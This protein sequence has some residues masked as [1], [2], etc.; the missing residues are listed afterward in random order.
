VAQINQDRYEVLAAR[1]LGVKGA[2]I[3]GHAEDAIFASLLLDTN[4]PVELWYPQRIYRFGVGLFVAA[5]AGRLGG[6]QLR[7]T[8][9]DQVWV[10]EHVHAS[11]VTGTNTFGLWVGE[12]VAADLYASALLASSLD[13]R[14][15]GTAVQDMGSQGTSVGLPPGH[16]QIDVVDCTPGSPCKFDPKVVLSPGGS[17]IARCENSN[18]DCRFG[19]YFH[20][21]Q[22]MPGELT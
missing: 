19:I 14:Q 22:A 18:V 16:G 17:F 7:N 20:T 11:L 4:S 21:R 9:S 13:T 15:P 3:L 1:A 12:D 8:S 5:I 10:V 2:G 6:I